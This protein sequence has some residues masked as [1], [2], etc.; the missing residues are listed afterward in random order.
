[1]HESLVNYLHHKVREELE[2]EPEYLV[3][4]LR[5]FPGLCWHHCQTI[6]YQCDLGQVT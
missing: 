3:F 2:V 6:Y 1:M 5:L 4:P